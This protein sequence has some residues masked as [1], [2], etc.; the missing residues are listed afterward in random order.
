MS[1]DR[2]P[3]AGKVEGEY[4]DAAVHTIGIVF[5]WKY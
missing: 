3:L 1:L 5:R 4:K 2:G